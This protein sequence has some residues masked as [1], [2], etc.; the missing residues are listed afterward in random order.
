METN[1]PHWSFPSKW[2]LMSVF[3]HWRNYPGMHGW[4]LLVEPL[5]IS[6]FHWS[7]EAC[8]GFSKIT[9]AS[10]IAKVL[11]GVSDCRNVSLLNFFSWYLLVPFPVSSDVCLTFFW[12]VPLSRS[13]RLLILHFQKS[14]P[15][16]SGYVLVWSCWPSVLVPGCCLNVAKM[17]RLSPV[18]PLSHAPAWGPVKD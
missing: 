7:F 12:L 15:W 1:K 5:I 18:S 17:C 9:T 10:W 2:D 4:E 3:E 14:H 11:F 13:I 16:K 8:L 6:I